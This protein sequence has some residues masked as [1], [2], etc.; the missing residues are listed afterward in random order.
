MTI[1]IKS[2]I[3]GDVIFEY[4]G[5]SLKNAILIDV[6]LSYA[7]LT[8]TD[9]S[10]AILIN[11]N[12]SNADLRI[13]DLSNA[14]L[15]NANLS[16]ADLRIA[17]LINANLTNADLSYADLSNAYLGIAD[18]SN[19]NLSNADL[20]H[21]NFSHANLRLSDLSNADLSDVYLGD[22][23][24]M[25]SNLRNADLT[26]TEFRNAKLEYKNLIKA[27]L[28]KIKEDFYEVLN[29]AIPEIDFLEKSILEGKI[30]GSTYEGKCACLC[31]TIEKSGR[32]GYECDM[33]DPNRPIERFFLAIRAGDTP[34]Y[35]P[36][37]R[38]VFD[39]L[40]EFKEKIKF[41]NK[42]GE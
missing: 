11:A 19:A 2:R 31:G 13:A 34:V 5:D 16:H 1:Q 15:S 6:N 9:L 41:E 42:I 10:N 39:W 7:D 21:A 4:P 28:S 36:V 22:A 40:Q 27:N 25:G 12:L 30:D 33:R 37:S 26:G 17:D 24:L 32:F 38:I 3:S 29:Q 23:N 14:I 20:S 18:L 35:N 8:N